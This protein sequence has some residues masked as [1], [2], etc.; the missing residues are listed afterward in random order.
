MNL[1]VY[2]P[3]CAD[4]NET[5]MKRSAIA[6]VNGQPWHM[7]QPLTEDCELRLI[8]MKD[9]DPKEANKVRGLHVVYNKKTTIFYLK[10]FKGGVGSQQRFK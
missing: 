2:L 6:L 7:L 8:T 4:F 1:V 9:D 5:Y 10:L 3:L